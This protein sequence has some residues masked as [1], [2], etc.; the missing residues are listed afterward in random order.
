MR[1]SRFSP[2]TLLTAVFAFLLCAAAEAAVIASVD[3]A[4]I[5]LN[6]S[7]TLKI[8]VDTAID[9]EPDATA[10]EEDFVVGGRSQLSNTT[11]VNGQISRS[12]TWT[13]M[14]MAKREGDL[15]IP[16][17]IIGSER[18][19][20]VPIKVTA[21]TNALPGEAD[22][23][24]TTEVDHTDSFVQAQL[25]YTVKVYRSVATRQPRL[26][27]PDIR[28]VEVLIEVAGEERSYESI[29]DGKA[30]NVVE[31]VYAIFPQESGEITIAPARFEARVLRDGRIT[32]RKIFES[33]AIQVVVSPIPPPPAAFPNA[34]W[35][36]AR[37][38]TLSQE[39]SRAPDELP[40]GEP[41]TRHIT[42]SALG[43]L[44][45]QIPVIEPIVAD[46]VKIYPDKPELR[47][48]AEASGMRALRKDQYAMIGIA[49]GK[50][51]LPEL[52]L[53][54]WNIDAG[55][56]QVARLPGTSISVLPSANAAA[57]PP[58]VTEQEPV[59]EP[60]VAGDSAV[61]VQSDFW[62]RSSAVLAGIWLLTVA[63]WWWSRRP[64]TRT[65]KEPAPPPV[66]KE[67][68]K[69]LKTA[70]MAATAGDGAGV[71]AAVLSWGRLEWPDNPPRNIGSVAARVAMP[72]STQLEALCR[73][74]YGPRK[75]AFDGEA[76]AKSLRNV[77]VLQEGKAERPTDGLPPLMPQSG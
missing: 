17:V 23:F 71:R 65:P 45:T 36:P 54:W 34:V 8:T 1:N 24:V 21:L 68:A 12:R 60:A 56:W 77:A 7:F 70:R 18:S 32:G 51:E 76:L 29:L 40:A 38:V 66:Y 35:F 33:N 75:T 28:G 69:L 47:D 72:L 6:E 19:E 5:E 37:E 22:I 63:M 74:D 26:S 53:P 30:Y 43:Q 62:R 27:E 2:N 10:L 52:R 67:Q 57:L 11:I 20:P 39:W 49:P 73:A 48:S 42:V 16:P 58:V 55:E 59:T 14:L 46:S 41:I 31:R 3:R 4:D 13:Y 15:V 44:S 64:A 61:I 50:V 25:L 9:S